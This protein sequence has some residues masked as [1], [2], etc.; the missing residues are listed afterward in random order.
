MT[1]EIV[2]V[3]WLSI[4]AASRRVSAAMSGQ[5]NVRHHA[6]SVGRDTARHA[7]G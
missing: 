3:S 2:R 4:A 6:F 1:R 7:T 5:A